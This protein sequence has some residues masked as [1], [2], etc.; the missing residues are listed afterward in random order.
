MARTDEHEKLFDAAQEVV[1]ES[2]ATA[3]RVADDRG[4]D[5][6]RLIRASF[7][8]LQALGYGLGYGPPGDRPKAKPKPRSR[9]KR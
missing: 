5:P 6:Q 4:V 9:P 8:Q 7:T 3:L 1:R 2:F